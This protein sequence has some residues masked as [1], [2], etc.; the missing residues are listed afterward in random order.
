MNA[1]RASSAA[2]G[3]RQFL[4]VPKA[5]L[6][7]AGISQAQRRRTYMVDLEFVSP[8]EGLAAGELC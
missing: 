4:V 3:I 6:G 1:S 7:P 5:I 2:H 8:A